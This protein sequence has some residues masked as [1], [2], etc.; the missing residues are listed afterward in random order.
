MI[1]IRTRLRE[2]YRSTNWRHVASD[3]F[4]TLLAVVAAGMVTAY[5]S[6]RELAKGEWTVAH[7]RFGVEGPDQTLVV[8]ILAGFLTAPVFYAAWRFADRRF[9]RSH[10]A[11]R[12][13]GVWAAIGIGIPVV[14][15]LARTSYD[16]A[17]VS[18]WIEANALVGLAQPFG[19]LLA[20]TLFPTVFTGVALRLSTG[21]WTLRTR[22]FRV[23]AAVV[24][25]V[26]VAAVGASATLAAPAD[27]TADDAS[28]IGGSENRPTDP[29]VFRDGAYGP[30]FDP[31]RYVNQSYAD[32][33]SVETVGCGGVSAPD[34]QLESYTPKQTTAGGDHFEVAAGQLATADGVVTLDTR[35]SVRLPNA[36]LADATVLRA[37]YYGV[38]PRD[39][40]NYSVG[41]SGYYDTPGGLQESHHYGLK[42]RMENV[43]SMHVYIDV[44]RD[45]EIHRYTTTLCPS[46]EPRTA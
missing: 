5:L 3:L 36:T 38:E 21:E 37:G 25:V 41:Y 32:Y 28:L 34:S 12:A 14:V 8:A 7:L 44:V 24:A 15:L 39:P 22:G 10:V 4:A 30:D 33:Q 35:Y 31:D 19:E 13:L 1:Q 2:W 42:V 26:L 23:T 6:L 29:A 45:G 11:S 17:A 20:L 18:R 16:P 43:E 9:P 40:Y 46:N 27:E